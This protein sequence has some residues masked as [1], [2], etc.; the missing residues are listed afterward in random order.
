MPNDTGLAFVVIMH[1]APEYESNL[2]E[3]LQQRT[4]MPVVQVTERVQV[5]PN[6]VYVIPPN[7][8][9][10]MSD[11][12]LVL[13]EPQ[14]TQGRRVTI[15]L[16]FRTLAEQYGQR[17]LCIVLSGS[18]SDGAIGLKHIK[19]QGGV[20]IAQDPNE[21]EHDV[22]PRS[23]I[24]TGMVDW[25][26]PVKQMVPRL[27]EYVHN[28]RR[29]KLPPEEDGDGEA[30]SLPDLAPRGIGGPLVSKISE[31]EADENALHQ[32][33]M[34]LRMQTGHDFSHYKRATLLRRIARRLQVNSLDDVPAYLSFMHTHPGEARALLHDLL[35][36]VTHFFRD[37]Q[38]SPCS[39]RTSPNSSAENRVATSF[40]C[41]CRVAR[42]ARKRIRSRCCWQSNR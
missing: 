1:L 4:K 20:T 5:T 24:E 17:A 8:H 18:D 13:S 25:V 2:A 34:F 16:F 3:I 39:K 35:I 23:A 21:S 22:M 42:P 37:Q 6:Q 7:K 41:G 9:L 31:S 40:G 32:V 19:A 10:T 26:L 15:D 36:G 29:M 14:K 30:T 11:S 38:R 12:M 28:E 33:L 27:L